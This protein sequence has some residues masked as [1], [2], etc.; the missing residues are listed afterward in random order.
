MSFLFKNHFRLPFKNNA[1]VSSYMSSY[2]NRPS[3][4]ETVARI[5]G[6]LQNAKQ[7]NAKRAHL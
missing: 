6:N 7:Q 1:T 5:Y 2:Y 3:A 4:E